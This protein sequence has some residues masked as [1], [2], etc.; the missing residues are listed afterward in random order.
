MK[1]Y[2]AY[3]KLLGN[4]DI[5]FMVEGKSTLDHTNGHNRQ[6]SKHYISLSDKLKGNCKGD[7]VGYI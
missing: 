6:R 3:S 7:K 5:K 4:K 1:Q 2:V